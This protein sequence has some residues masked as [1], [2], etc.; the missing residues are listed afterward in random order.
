M[1]LFE[2]RCAV[3]TGAGSGFGREFAR[4]AARRKMRVV[5]ADVQKDALK[6][7]EAEL[8][9]EGV[10]LIAQ[11]CDVSNETEV[12]ALAD[13][14]FEHFGAVHLL[15]N[16]A[17]VATGGLTWEAS[18]AD[19]QWVLGVN[20]MGVVHGI[21]AFVPRMIAAGQEGHVINTASVAGLLSPPLMAVYNV[22][23][24]A[25][26]TLSETLYHDLRLEKTKLGVTVLCPA[27]VPTGISASERNR[28]SHLDR[29]RE[30]T[31]SEIAAQQSSDKAVSSGK[32]TAA[33]VASMTFD[34]IE[35]EQFYCVTHPKIMPSVRTRCEDVSQLRNP[36]DPYAHKPEVANTATTTSRGV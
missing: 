18:A 19:W 24:H 3:I 14:A 29:G 7:V 25:V 8:R 36:T 4:I 32:I 1:K 12:A 20:V 33:Q 17:G 26:V 21:K 10:D 30:A 23:K 13:A 2:G 35:S 28:P 6:A 34:A 5:L 15:F 31:A 9:A 27:F 16:N 11:P 22:S